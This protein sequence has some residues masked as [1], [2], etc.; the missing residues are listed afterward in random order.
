MAAKKDPTVSTTST[1]ASE[2]DNPDVPGT[3]AA[4]PIDEADHSAT[5]LEGSYRDNPDKPAESSIA[6]VQDVPD[7]WPGTGVPADSGK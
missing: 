1:T 4:R 3:H 2:M 6:Q 5:Q 7:G